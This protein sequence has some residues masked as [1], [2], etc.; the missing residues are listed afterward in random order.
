MLKTVA[1]DWLL[2]VVVG[3]AGGGAL[4]CLIQWNGLGMVGW[5]CV[6][7]FCLAAGDRHTYHDLPIADRPLSRQHAAPAG[8]CQQCHGAGAYFTH[9]DDCTNEFCAINGGIDSC[10]G[11]V[12]K[13][14]DCRPAAPDEDVGS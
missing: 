5:L 13:C 4:L 2:R 8:E 6:I 11:K 3:V 10:V 7:A 1:K 9:A 12:E 14:W